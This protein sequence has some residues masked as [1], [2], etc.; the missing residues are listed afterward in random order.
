MNGNDINRILNDDTNLREAIKRR[1]QKQPPMPADL[2]ARLM[3][4]MEREPHRQ[5][6]AMWKWVAATA[7]LLLLIGIGYALMPGE[8]QGEPLVAQKTVQPQI[9]MPKTEPESK[10]KP[11][12]ENISPQPT[13]SQSATDGQRV[14]NRRTKAIIVKKQEIE[15]QEV[16]TNREKGTQEPMPDVMADPFLMAEMHAQQIHARGMR[17]EQEIKQQLNINDRPL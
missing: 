16:I 6:T 10:E 13:D 8:Q 5:P 17:L 15:E 1:E 9:E 7:C 4:R 14:R 12:E 2:N 11:Q 3:Q